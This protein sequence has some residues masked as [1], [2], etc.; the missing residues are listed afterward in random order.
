MTTLAELP[1][2]DLTHT[3][4]HTRTRF[5]ARDGAKAGHPT[6]HVT[7]G[8]GRDSRH[9]PLRGPFT[10]DPE[11]ARAHSLNCVSRERVQL[12]RDPEQTLSHDRSARSCRGSTYQILAEASS[13]LM[14]RLTGPPPH[15]CTSFPARTGRIWP[16][17]RSKFSAALARGER[18][19]VFHRVIL[20]DALAV[21]RLFGTRPPP[22]RLKP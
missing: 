22:P 5:G 16:W 2:P 3:T 1:K 10:R 15:I 9:H 14:Q 19:A 18:R 12:F 4:L 7:R 13:A 8:K 17:N 6:R 21:A 20:T 11:H